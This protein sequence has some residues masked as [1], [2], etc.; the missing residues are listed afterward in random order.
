[1]FLRK[2]EQAEYQQDEGEEDMMSGH[3]NRSY[4]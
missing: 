1:M 2:G 4:F 3:K